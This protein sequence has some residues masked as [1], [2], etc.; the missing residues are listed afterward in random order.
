MSARPAAATT[1]ALL[2]LATA[3]PADAAEPRTVDVRT[4]TV[5]GAPAEPGT[6]R[7]GT[8]THRTRTRADASTGGDAP[9]VVNL[10]DL[11]YAP[12]RLILKLTDDAGG[13]SLDARR[14]GTARGGELGVDALDEL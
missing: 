14:A 11:P 3:A 9:P 13:R 5:D 10:D 1:T 12:G 7:Y 2:F 6:A 4:T 8:L